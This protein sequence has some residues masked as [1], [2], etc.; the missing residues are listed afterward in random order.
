MANVVTV[1][2]NKSVT[3]SC[4]R[5]CFYFILW[6][7][8]AGRNVQSYEKQSFLSF[9][10]RLGPFPQVFRQLKEWLILEFHDKSVTCSYVSNC[11]Y[12]VLW[13]RWAGRSVQSYEKWSSFSIFDRLGPFPYVSGQVRDW[14]ILELYEIIRVLHVLMCPMNFDLLCDLSLQLGVLKM[15][16]F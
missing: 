11:F 8:L 14:L 2:N 4:V 10:S 3:C 5:N 13:W 1:Q 12:F 16:L 9:F 7:R 15:F 6:A